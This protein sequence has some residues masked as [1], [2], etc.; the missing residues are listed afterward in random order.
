MQREA[1]V[2]SRMAWLG[3][4]AVIV[5]AWAEAGCQYP[6][7]FVYTYREFDRSADTFRREPSGRDWVTVCTR[8]FAAPD[9]NVSVLAEEQCQKHGKTAVEATRRFGECPLLLSE[10]V[11]YRCA[12]PAS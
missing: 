7:P 2:R 5:A 11:V 1:N 8:P 3:A 9:A 12:G 4:A 10:A 6:Q